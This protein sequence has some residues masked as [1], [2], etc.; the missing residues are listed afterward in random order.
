MKSLSNLH[1]SKDLKSLL[2][3]GG[4][5]PQGIVPFMDK[6]DE[7]LKLKAKGIRVNFHPGAKIDKNTAKAIKEIADVISFDFISDEYTIKQVY[8]GFYN[9]DDYITSIENLI[10]NNIRVVPHILCGVLYGNI[11]GERKAILRLKE[12]GFNEAV[13]LVLRPPKDSDIH[14]PEPEKIIDVVKDI[15]MNITLG[16][17]RPGGNYRKKI[18]ILAAQNNFST[19]VMPHPDCERYCMENDYIIEKGDECCVF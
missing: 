13:L 7:I 1:L 2:I 6:K 4:V 15:D 18:D 17:M 10:N 19:I 11:K 5:N 14:S 8:K 16:C 9:A 12:M 3:S